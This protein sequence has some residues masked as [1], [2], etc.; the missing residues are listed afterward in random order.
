MLGYRVACWTK[1]SSKGGFQAQ[2]KEEKCE[3]GDAARRGRCHGCGRRVNRVKHDGAGN[4]E[5]DADGLRRTWRFFGC[6]HSL[7]DDGEVVKTQDR[8]WGVMAGAPVQP[9]ATVFFST[10][11]CAGRILPAPVPVPRALKGEILH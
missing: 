7:V 9:L 11:P 3:N 6:A 2:G 1:T 8:S 4:F 5:M 10:G